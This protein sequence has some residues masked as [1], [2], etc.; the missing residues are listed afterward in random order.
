MITVIEQPEPEQSD[1]IKGATMISGGTGSGKMV[2]LVIE[3]QQVTHY[4]VFEPV[5]LELGT[6]T[7]LTH[8]DEFPSIR[9]EIT[10]EELQS[11]LDQ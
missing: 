3:N 7:T 10:V 2:A 9:S 11:I 1:L 6:I 5:P 4:R 8:H